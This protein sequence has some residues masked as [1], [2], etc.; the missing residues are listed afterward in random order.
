MKLT[1]IKC[2][3]SYRKSIYVDHYGF[4]QYINLSSHL[5]IDRARVFIHHPLTFAV[6]EVV[7]TLPVHSASVI[8]LDLDIDV[9]QYRSIKS[10]PRY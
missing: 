2:I 10:R 8:N 9:K 1:S 3:E 7:Y 5:I 6:F 4:L